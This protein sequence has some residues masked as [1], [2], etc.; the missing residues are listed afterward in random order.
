[1]ADDTNEGRQRRVEPEQ[2]VKPGEMDAII[3][4]IEGVSLHESVFGK[5][6]RMFIEKDGVLVELDPDT[7]EVIEIEIIISDDPG[8]AFIDALDL[9][10][11][12]MLKHQFYTSVVAALDQDERDELVAGTPIFQATAWMDLIQ[13]K[14]V[15]VSDGMD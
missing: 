4:N 13:R 2:D 15:E 5:P 14:L 12:T 11:R 3:R 9:M 7:H 6:S 10:T 1:M 8:V